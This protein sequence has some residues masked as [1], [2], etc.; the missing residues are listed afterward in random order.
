MVTTV[1][2]IIGYQSFLGQSCML[3]PPIKSIYIINLHLP[4]FIQGD[5]CGHTSIEMI[6]I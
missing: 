2:S 3:I 5:N 6:E 1:L 4:P